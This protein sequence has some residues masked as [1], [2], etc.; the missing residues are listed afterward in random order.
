MVDF[1]ELKEAQSV[2]GVEQSADGGRAR[3]G[4]IEVR[5]RRMGTSGQGSAFPLR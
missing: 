4:A 3:I 1:Q 5:E 2:L